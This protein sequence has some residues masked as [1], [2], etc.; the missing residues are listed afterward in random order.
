MKLV[1]FEDPSWRELWPLSTVKPVFLLEVGG[2][3]LYEYWV[4]A[5]NPEGVA[6][7]L[8]P[9]VAGLYD[10]LLNIREES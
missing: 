5:L 1:F 4:D 6:F 9:E 8:R 10:W 2:R 3:R 7:F